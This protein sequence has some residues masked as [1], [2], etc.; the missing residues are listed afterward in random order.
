MG[1]NWFNCVGV[2]NNREFE[3]LGV[4][5]TMLEGGKFKGNNEFEMGKSGF[6]C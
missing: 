2:L 6:Y 5:F 1:V 4:K 3:E